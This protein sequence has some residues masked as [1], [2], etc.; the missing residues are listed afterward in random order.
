MG[1]PAEKQAFSVDQCKSLVGFK[2]FVPMEPILQQFDTK[3]KIAAKSVS[4]GCD[5]RIS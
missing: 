4:F 2:S 5:S 3:S 1:A